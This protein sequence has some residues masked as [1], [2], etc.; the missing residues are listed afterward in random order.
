MMHFQD[1]YHMKILKIEN[2]KNADLRR[3]YSNLLL[4]MAVALKLPTTLQ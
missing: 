1:N 4:Q 3:H 2:S